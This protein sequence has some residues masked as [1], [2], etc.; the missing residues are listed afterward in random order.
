MR[1]GCCNNRHETKRFWRSDPLVQTIDKD[2][3]NILSGFGM[4]DGE[5]KK[6]I[7]MYYTYLDT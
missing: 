3:R 5:E 6:W 1:H 2:M 4:D 7:I